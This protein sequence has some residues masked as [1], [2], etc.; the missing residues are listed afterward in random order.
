MNKNK[1]YHKLNGKKYVLRTGQKGGKY[2]IVNNEKKYI[3]KTK[4][5]AD[6]NLLDTYT[7]IVTT[8]IPYTKT[9]INTEY[10]THIQIVENTENKNYKEDFTVFPDPVIDLKNKDYN[11]WINNIPFQLTDNKPTA[12]FFV[13]WTLP[14]NAK[15][16]IIG[17]IHG[18]YNSLL[19]LLANWEISGYIYKEGDSIKLKDDI[20]IISTGDI[21]DYGVNSLNVVYDL[22]MLRHNNP[23]KVM[24]LSGNHEGSA[25]IELVLGF[26]D[27]FKE[28]TSK[29]NLDKENSDR[30]L[31]YIYCI[32]PDMLSLRFEN[33][34]ESIY[35][36]HGMYPVTLR[37]S[38]DTL[39]NN[40]TDLNIWPDINRDKLK[41]KFTLEEIKK[42]KEKNKTE[43]I[44]PNFS[45]ATQWNDIASTIFTKNSR[46]SFKHLFELGIDV[47]YPIMI[48]YGIK[49]FIRGHQDNCPA[50]FFPVDINDQVCGN[51]IGL[52]FEDKNDPR[53]VKC[54][55]KI[56]SNNWCTYKTSYSKLPEISYIHNNLTAP[57]ETTN[58][59]KFLK[60]ASI[61]KKTPEDIIKWEG[62]LH[63]ALY[64][65]KERII[66][67]SMAGQKRYA[68][69]GGY[70][71][72]T[73]ENDDLYAGG[74]NKKKYNKNLLKYMPFGGNKLPS[75]TQFNTLHTN[76][77]YNYDKLK[78]KLKK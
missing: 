2:I 36:M 77:A 14:S 56:D 11:S 16:L 61:N 35:L 19:K 47:L 13:D 43:P 3:K 8:P 62:I 41:D 66:T 5:G 63:N 4:G 1:E 60:D 71:L 6:V 68:P 72:L 51:A 26:D 75:L 70:I 58:L 44:P 57:L 31:N 78:N 21:I 76:E 40:T 7:N 73:V 27:F 67:I 50:Q 22:V 64:I 46:R 37:N 33:E 39:S 49:G 65:M 9:D 25:G 23:G 24:L 10:T 18:D 45:H 54:V 15:V 12:P 17:D 59:V 48:K 30:L 69:L 28:I 38:V 42:I 55:Q 32:G 53:T 29:L 20:Y 52:K 34:A 74:S